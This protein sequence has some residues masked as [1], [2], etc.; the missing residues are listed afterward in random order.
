MKE[1]WK[2]I[3]GYEGL[4]QVSNIGRIKS[5]HPRYK[6]PRILK[7]HKRT[8]GYIFICLHKD[9]KLFTVDVHRLVAEA[10]VPNPNADEYK[11][12]LHLDDNQENNV[13]TNLKWGTQKEN[14][15]TK[16]HHEALSRSMRNRV[17]E[18]NSF[19]GKKH[20]EETKKKIS[21]SHGIKVE[22]DGMIFNSI[23]ECA[24]YANINPSSLRRYLRGLQKT[25]KG[26]NK[27]FKLIGV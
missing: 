3:N 11:Y 5:F 7:T 15:N 22:C 23:K 21:E 24:E 17:G 18:K 8:N 27:S 14:C 12:V 25:L 9:K 26:T 4:Y 19:Y 16:H 10:F 20:T 2:D 1:I 13:Y 6:E